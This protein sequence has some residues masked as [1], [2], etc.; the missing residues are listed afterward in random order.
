MLFMNLQ[1]ITS[2][3]NEIYEVTSGL[4]RFTFTKVGHP[5]VAYVGYNDKVQ[6]LFLQYHDGTSCYYN[7]VSQYYFDNIVLKKQGDSYSIYEAILSKESMPCSEKITKVSA[8]KV[9]SQYAE[10]KEHFYNQ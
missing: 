6:I 7:G 2:I 1:N 3:G 5:T 8:E 4:E 10:L 9:V